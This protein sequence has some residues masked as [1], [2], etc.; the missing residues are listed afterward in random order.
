MVTAE[1][2]IKTVAA[3]RPKPNDHQLYVASL[4]RHQL[5]VAF[6]AAV[7]LASLSA[8]PT[9]SKSTGDGCAGR[10]FFRSFSSSEKSFIAVAKFF[11]NWST[12][13][14]T[15]MLLCSAKFPARQRSR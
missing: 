7:G 8:S 9:R 3:A 4:K 14:G 15:V 13:T 10:S 5:E 12:H 11:S 1:N 6:P 2:K